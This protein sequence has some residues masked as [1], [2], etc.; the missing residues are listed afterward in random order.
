MA[1][2][3]VERLLEE[4]SNLSVLELAELTQSIEEKFGVSATVAAAP[5]AAAP[6]EGE[7]QESQEEE[8]AEFN[9]QLEAYGDS[10]TGVIK[11]LR[12]VN[13]DISLKE[14]KSLVEDA[15]VT[16]AESVPKDE[17]HEMK[18]TLEEAGGTIKLT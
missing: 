14:A 6:A 1:S 7:Q 13:K 11:A 9:V 16:L 2:N 8:K 12:K 3:N 18:K 17:A 5:A 15:P 10:K 4:I